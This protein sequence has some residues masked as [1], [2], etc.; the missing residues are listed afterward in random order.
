LK[1]PLA[2]GSGV[3]RS[4][5]ASSAAKLRRRMSI[6][7]VLEMTAGP[8]AASR[9]RHAD[10]DQSLGQRRH[11]GC[12]RPQ[13]QEQ[14]VEV[15]SPGERDLS[16]RRARPIIG[17]VDSGHAYLTTVPI[18]M[19]HRASQAVNRSAGGG[20]RTIALRGGE[21]SYFL[22]RGALPRS[23]AWVALVVHVVGCVSGPPATGCAEMASCLAPGRPWRGKATHGDTWLR[24]VTL[25][26]RTV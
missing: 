14:R 26:L 24:K 6:G 23:R 2:A 19:L 22:H 16:A 9:V 10:V 20:R 7:L 8:E 12:L 18:P 25:I 4:S 3:D 15:R 17:V 21:K 1:L 11:P 5:S 13:P